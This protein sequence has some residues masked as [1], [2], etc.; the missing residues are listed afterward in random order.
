MKAA[1]ACVALITLI[2]ACATQPPEPTSRRLTGDTFDDVPAPESAVFRSGAG[3]SFAF[4]SSGFRC[5]RF[6]FDYPGADTEAI[7]FFKETMQHP[8]Y[9]W[10]LT[11]EQREVEGST[12]LTLVKGG[13]TCTVNVDRVPAR[14]SVVLTLRVNYRK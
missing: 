11:N 5:G 13:D 10:K 14:E 8:P 2:T 12:R 9:S 4:Q 7:R 1:L 3:E 6:V